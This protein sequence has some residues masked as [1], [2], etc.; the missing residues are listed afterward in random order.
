MLLLLSFWL[1]VGAWAQGAKTSEP[2]SVRV[3][4][5]K[6]GQFVWEPDAAPQGPV[7]IL[8]NLAEQFAVVYRNG[9]RIGATNVSTGRPG[10]TTPTG[11]FT[12]LQKDANHH[13][14][15]Y[16]KALMPYTER[17]TWSGVAL[18]AGG[19]PG[20][21][22]SHG[23]I[24]LPLAFAKELFGVTTTGMTV[25]ITDTPVRPA[26]PTASALLATYDPR[27]RSGAIAAEGATSGWTPERAPA[28]PL[29]IIISGADRHLVVMRNGVEIGW[30]RVELSGA[31]P[32][33]THA[34]TLVAGNGEKADPDEFAK[35]G[36][37]W[38]QVTLPSAAPD[39]ADGT[40][41]LG[42][43]SVPNGFLAQLLPAI[44]AGTTI[45]ITDLSLSAT[46]RAGPMT[47]IASK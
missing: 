37:R 32:L 15:I 23:C 20:Y 5:L 26:T 28:G 19:L 42:R 12:I 43:V 22:S 46:G 47:V 18:H 40:A 4:D 33:G 27:G 21:P 14:S 41:A 31:D 38:H 29:S 11:V 39:D 34:L 25:V 45:V 9:I 24:H 3:F 44:E 2:A 17:L 7:V 16:N 13:S 30:A 8:V 10:F 35:A 36:Y 1:P 6:P